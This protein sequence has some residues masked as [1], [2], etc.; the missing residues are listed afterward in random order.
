MKSKELKNYNLPDNRIYNDVLDA[1]PG[2]LLLFIMIIGFILLIKKIYV[3]G[4]ALFFLGAACLIFLPNRK[5]IE[6][7]DDCMIIYNKARKDECNIIYYDDVKSWEYHTSVSDDEL[8]FVLEDGSVQ[9][10]DA[11]SK[12]DFE[13]QLDKYM[14]DK[15][16]IVESK[17]IFKKQ[18][19]N[20]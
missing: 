6:F 14:K 9:K 8:I 18:G 11:Y 2:K 1:K 7:Y 10:I 19:G 13:K 12:I 20:K 15:K 17:N 4:C 3:F 5:L 16:V